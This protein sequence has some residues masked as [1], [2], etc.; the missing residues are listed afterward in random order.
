MCR[1]GLI[2]HCGSGVIY[3]IR[4]EPDNVC[5]LLMHFIVHKLSAVLASVSWEASSANVANTFRERRQLGAEKPPK[6]RTCSALGKG[7]ALCC[8]LDTFSVHLINK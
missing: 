4:K 5:S 1:D 8:S 3:P 6:P 7:T 2:P